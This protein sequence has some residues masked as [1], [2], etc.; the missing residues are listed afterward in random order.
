M[1]VTIDLGLIS[2]LGSDYSTDEDK[3]PVVLNVS[4][5]LPS[6]KQLRQLVDLRRHVIVNGYSGGKGIGLN[7]LEP[8]IS[9]LTSLAINLSRSDQ[10]DVRILERAASL[11]TLI[12]IDSAP[13]ETVD[14]AALPNLSRFD[15]TLLPQLISVLDNPSLT[16]LKIEGPQPRDFREI[17]A[18]LSRLHIA[19]RP[20]TNQLPSLK[21]PRKLKY[22]RVD[23][24]RK[25]NAASLLVASNLEVLHL[26]S[27]GNLQNVT[28]LSQ[29]SHLE[30]LVMMARCEE[31]WDH[32]L[33]SHVKVA[34]MELD[35]SPS[36][37]FRN[38]AARRGWYVSGKT[39]AAPKGMAPFTIL[40]PWTVDGG[41]VLHLGNFGAMS[42]LIV[43]TLGEKQYG[44]LE[45][46]GHIVEALVRAACKADTE[47]AA[48]DVTFDSESEGFYAAFP[49]KKLAQ[50]A[51]RLTLKLLRDATKLSFALSVSAG[52]H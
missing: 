22:F 2:F 50:R 34:S 51:A 37:R 42:D 29:L 8:V 45:V 20:S 33:D 47:L 41:P 12:W 19:S 46:N 14:L 43:N 38:E 36:A 25:F 1:K 7:F 18:P 4:R 6:E 32:L 21:Y 30:E 15:G 49:T 9:E 27:V 40:E 35:P 44:D 23:V 13:G 31:D 24:P 16:D 48:A 52:G 17:G 11:R 39:D 5:P 10:A 3:W 26:Y 28:T